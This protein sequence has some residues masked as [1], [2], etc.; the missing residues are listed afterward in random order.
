MPYSHEYR[1]SCSRE[2]RMPYSREYRMPYSQEYRMLYSRVM[3]GCSRSIPSLVM[4]GGSVEY[5]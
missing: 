1:M 2:Y 3:G 4:G 5:P